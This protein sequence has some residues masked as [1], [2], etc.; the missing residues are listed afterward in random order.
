MAHATWTGI[1][2]SMGWMQVVING[3]LAL[4]FA[5]FAWGKR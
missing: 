4:G 5:Y 2:N 1:V 3:L